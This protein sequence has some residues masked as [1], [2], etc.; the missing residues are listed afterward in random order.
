MDLGLKGRRALVTG[1][2]QGI[3]RAVARALALEGAR[4]AGAAR[5][6][7]DVAALAAA[8]AAE[9]GA[10]IVPLAAD[11]MAPGA[12]VALAAAAEAALGGVDILVNAAGGSRPLAF[13][14]PREA[15]DEG[16]ELNF[17]RLRELTHALVP[18]MRARGWGRIVNFTGTSEPRIINAAFAAKAAVHVW[19]KGLSREV[20][21]DGVTINCLQPGRIRSEQIA[22]R[23]PTPEAERE[24]AEAEIPA[25]R[26]G[27]PGEIAD[28]AVFLASARAAYVTGT[29]IP[30]DGGMSRFAF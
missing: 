17:H 10:E 21:A 1:A 14:A 18:G 24:F 22:R 15:W 7:E 11:L 30:V 29:V 19:S 2:S 20:A 25:L 16:M 4:V 3:G 23:Y 8:V 12:P 27:E 5:R 13:D 26:F 28:L 9:G 6:A